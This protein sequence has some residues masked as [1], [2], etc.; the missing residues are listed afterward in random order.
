MCNVESPNDK[1][2]NQTLFFFIPSLLLI[3]PSPFFTVEG[4]HDNSA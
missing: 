4:R 2:P 1:K 3:F